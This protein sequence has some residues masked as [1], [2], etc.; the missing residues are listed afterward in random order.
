[1][2]ICDAASCRQTTRSHRF[3]RENNNL[4]RFLVLY[5]RLYGIAYPAPIS[6]V[7]LVVFSRAIKNAPN[8]PFGVFSTVI[9]IQRFSKGSFAF[10]DRTT[11]ECA[12]ELNNCILNMWVGCYQWLFGN[13]GTV[14]LVF[15]AVR[16]VTECFLTDVYAHPETILH[17]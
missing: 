14:S 1:M 2:A 17:G 8:K 15:S 4:N 3:P 11:S 13:S 5:W 6:C 9:E 16:Y 7:N 10:L 12:L